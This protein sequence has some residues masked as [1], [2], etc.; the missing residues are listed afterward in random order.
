MSQLKKIYDRV[1]S[2]KSDSDIKLSDIIVLI[3]A[4][5]FGN[6]GINGDHRVY[7]KADVVEIINL[8]PDKSDKSK[9][10]SYQVRQVRSIIKKY[11]MEIHNGL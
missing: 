2:G 4:L 9:A 5:G 7:G 1:V 6:K 11:N 3:E 10:K 8:Q